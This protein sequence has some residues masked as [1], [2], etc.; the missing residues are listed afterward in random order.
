MVADGILSINYAKWGESVIMIYEIADQNGRIL[1]VTADNAKNARRLVCIDLGIKPSEK[2]FRKLKIKSKT[3][4]EYKVRL[5]NSD[6][7]KEYANKNEAI[8]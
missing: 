7:T 3:K 4:Y 1:K 6:G 8:A 2:E 5:F